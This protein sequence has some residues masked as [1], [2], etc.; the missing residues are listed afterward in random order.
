M[1][2]DRKNRFDRAIHD[3]SAPSRA[4]GHEAHS[5]TTLPRVNFD[6]DLM[7]EV[8]SRLPRNNARYSAL[9]SAK[10]VE[11]DQLGKIAGEHASVCPRV[12]E[13]KMTYRLSGCRIA[14]DDRYDR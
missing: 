14:N 2:S 13:R 10:H 12:D 4:F 9:C 7:Q 1:R 5:Y 3:H 6:F 11:T 8:R